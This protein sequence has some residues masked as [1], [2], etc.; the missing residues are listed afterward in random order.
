VTGQRGQASVEL[1]ALAGLAAVAVL[2]LVQVLLAVWALERA[3]R[4]AGA[5][6]VLVAEGRGVPAELQD[7]ADVTVTGGE[8]RAAVRVPALLPGLPALRARARA[9]LP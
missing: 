9:R 8:V 6:A 5:A 3:E 1:A 7:E 4:V 2:G